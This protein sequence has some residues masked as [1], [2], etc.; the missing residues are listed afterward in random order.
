[1]LLLG[2]VETL[3]FSSDVPNNS[4]KADGRLFDGYYIPILRKV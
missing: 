4:D 2:Q 3:S 1:M